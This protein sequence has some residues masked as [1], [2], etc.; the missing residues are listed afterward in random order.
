MLKANYV[1][2]QDYVY[3]LT[4]DGLFTAIMVNYEIRENLGIDQ[5]LLLQKIFQPKPEHD[6]LST[7]MRYVL[8]NTINKGKD[9]FV[10]KIMHDIEESMEKIQ[11]PLDLGKV[12]LSMANIIIKGEGFPE[13][14]VISALVNLT[15]NDKIMVYDSFKLQFES[16]IYLK[17]IGTKGRILPT[18]LIDLIKSPEYVII[19]FHCECGYNTDQFTIPIIDVI[20]YFFSKKIIQCPMCQNKIIKNLNNPSVQKS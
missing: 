17:S 16:M 20:L 9:D 2:Q 10:I 1:H 7:F 19:P 4:E 12:A 14:C 8:L 18:N 5:K 15:P 6:A 3:E 13:E 11:D